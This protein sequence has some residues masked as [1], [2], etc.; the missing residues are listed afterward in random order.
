MNRLDPDRPTIPEI[1]PLIEAVYDRSGAGCCLHLVTDDENVEDSYV[2][3]CLDQAIERGHAD[4]ETAAR[5]L[6]RM[7]KTQR[8]KVWR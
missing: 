5:A 3:F 1:R 4:C 2:Q 6:M 7:S 8:L